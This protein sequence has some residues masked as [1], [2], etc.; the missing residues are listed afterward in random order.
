M[1]RHQFCMDSVCNLRA[2]ALI[3]NVYQATA[4]PQ[5]SSAIYYAILMRPAC[6]QPGVKVGSIVDNDFINIRSNHNRNYK[7]RFKIII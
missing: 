2:T 7:T 1:I 6:P 4:Y 5:D 3:Y